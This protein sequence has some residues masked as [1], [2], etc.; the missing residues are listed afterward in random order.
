MS[1]LHRDLGFS[2][3]QA[4]CLKQRHSVLCRAMGT[5]TGKFLTRQTKGLCKNGSRPHLTMPLSGSMW[6]A[7][8][9]SATAR[10]AF[11]PGFSRRTVILKELLPQDVTSCSNRSRLRDWVPHSMSMCAWSEPSPRAATLQTSLKAGSIP[12]SFTWTFSNGPPIPTK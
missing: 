6:D 7:A 5:P 8:T 10:N 1:L 4:T 11:A 3:L 12:P 9:N 2:I